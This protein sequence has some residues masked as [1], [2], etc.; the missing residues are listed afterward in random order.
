[1][2]V[3]WTKTFR[4]PEPGDA[5]QQYGYSQ[6]K[7]EVLMSK[8][9]LFLVILLSLGTHGYAADF[10]CAAGNVGCL[11][12]AI[13]VANANGEDNS[14]FLEIG[15]YTLHTPNAANLVNGLPAITGRIRIS[16]PEGIGSTIERDPTAPGFR[17]FEVAAGGNVALDWIGI[18]NGQPPA[19]S[20]QERCGGAILNAGSLT[21]NRTAIYRNR[22]D[23]HSGG[24]IC[25]TGKL[26]ISNSEI[27]RN[28]AGDDAGGAIFSS[29]SL[30]V[31]DS[32]ISTN[33]AN[34]GVA[35]DAQGTGVILRTTVSGN[36]S[37]KGAIR[38]FGTF[39][40]EDSSIT[41]NL[42]AAIYNFGTLTIVNTT[43][44][45]DRELVGGGGGIVNSGNMFIK[46]SSIVGN[47][48]STSAA[49]IQNTGTIR[50][51][52]SIL[53]LNT[54]GSSP[55]DCNSFTSL[56]NN[57]IGSL[58]GCTV[59]LRGSDIVGD[60][61][62]GTFIEDELVY[63]SGHV[64]LMPGSPAIGSGNDGA[65]TPRD[66]MGERRNGL[67]DIGAVQFQPSI[68]FLANWNRIRNSQGDSS[69]SESARFK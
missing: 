44:F 45:Q 55:A 12:S 34:F 32:R 17:I 42:G 25:S 23:F 36:T 15:E 48:T 22:T 11:I 31:E 39:W 47:S 13:E 14:I 69:R 64:P 54:R 38:T 10:F 52:N 28:I 3:N 18:R 68:E 20:T 19:T 46:N 61:G 5:A 6:P 41:R 37:D 40:I 50:L 8:F 1:V 16:G 21:I 56:G 58:E 4:R 26:S 67:C 29:G 62:L 30:L 35:I 57:I 53:A 60:P 51:Q 43:I 7:M 27:T 65:C 9:A 49:G 33:D 24:A 63:G 59:V 2:I 66:Q